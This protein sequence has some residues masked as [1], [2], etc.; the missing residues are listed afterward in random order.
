[1]LISPNKGGYTWVLDR[2]T[3]KFINAW[4]L[5]KNIN[6]IYRHRQGGQA[7]RSQRSGSRQADPGLPQHRRRP[8]LEPWRVRPKTGLFYTTAI[9]WCQ[10]LTVQKEEPKTGNTFFGGIFELRKP[11]IGK[12]GGHFDARDPVT[13]KIKW[14]YN[15]SIRCWPQPWPPRATSFS[16]AIPKVTSSR[17]TQPL[18]RSSGTSR[19]AQAIVDHHHLCGERQTVHRGPGGLG[20]CTGRPHDAAMAGSGRLSQEAA[21]SSCSHY[22]SEV[23]R[24]S[25]LSMSCAMGAD[26]D[27]AQIFK[28]RCSVGYCHGAEGKPGRAPKLRDR[29]FEAPYLNKV[30]T[31]GIS[32]SSMPGFKE[33]LKPAEIT[34]VVNYVLS[35]SGK[36]PQPVQQETQP[37]PATANLE[38]GKALFF[39]SNNEANCGVCHAIDDSGTAIGPDLRKLKLTS[40]QLFSV[41]TNPPKSKVTKLTLKSGETVTGIV[42]EDNG[43]TIRIHDTEGLP[44]VLRSIAKED[45]AKSEKIESQVMPKT[46][47]AQYTKDQL[48]EIIRYLRGAAF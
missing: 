6:W 5:A 29:D 32:K 43:K 39:D 26:I 18:A 16:P 19:P 3:G 12:Q 15:Q 34:A 48:T 27:G 31:D 36:P 1:M 14:T 4:P 37:A 20:L 41:I 9:E 13:G 25:L 7:A 10:Q 8:K 22:P 35:L 46:Y 23:D 47:G 42:T 45:I 33:I 2:A 30:V 17:W 24:N 40:E 44:P 28:L 21:R 11:P 38:K